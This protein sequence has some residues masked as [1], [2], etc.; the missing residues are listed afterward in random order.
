[1]VGDEFEAHFTFDRLKLELQSM[2]RQ[3]KGN[4]VVFLSKKTNRNVI[5]MVIMNDVLQA[6]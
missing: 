5:G 2:E 6:G 4:E 1:M 3:W